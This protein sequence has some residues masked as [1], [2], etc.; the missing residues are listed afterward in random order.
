MS[1]SSETNRTDSSRKTTQQSNSIPE[2]IRHLAEE[3]E[4][5]GANG[6][7]GNEMEI[8]ALIRNCPLLYDK[9]VSDFHDAT[10]KDQ[11]WRAIAQVFNVS[12]RDL[13]Q[14]WDTL[15]QEFLKFCSK[16]AEEK[17]YPS[18]LD[19]MQFLKSVSMRCRRP[20]CSSAVNQ[21]E[22]SN[23]SASSESD[24]PNDGNYRNELNLDTLIEKIR[25]NTILY[26]RKHKEAKNHDLKLK[27]WK[28]LA[29]EIGI[30]VSE[31]VNRWKI[32]REKYGRERKYRKAYPDGRKWYL[33]EKLSFLEGH[34]FKSFQ[35]IS[36][37][38][39]TPRCQA[40]FP[41][42]FSTKLRIH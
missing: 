4:I 19:E 18:Y 22:D 26:D 28:K 13:Q 34:V 33:F 30:P 7:E 24:V 5:D 42:V 39:R 2:H 11:A 17:T 35:P 14:F 20:S 25:V 15:K 9:S 16:S 8:I 10:K 27:T 40:D 36:G 21:K 29:K 12:S 37:N 31:C 6:L 23:S 41:R 32:L 1:H 38:I 3:L